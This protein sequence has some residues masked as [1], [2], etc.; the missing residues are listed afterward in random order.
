MVK[1]DIKRMKY[2]GYNVKKTKHLINDKTKK[3]YLIEYTIDGDK[4]KG[5]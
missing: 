5:L 3:T 1:K 2:L 4:P